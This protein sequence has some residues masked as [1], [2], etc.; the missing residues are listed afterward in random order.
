MCACLSCDPTANL[1]CNPGMC[2]DWE[3]NLQSFASQTHTESTE[4]H[5]PGQS[6]G[7]ILIG[8]CVY[9]DGFVHSRLLNI[10]NITSSVT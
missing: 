10:L 5:Q 1:D 6:V 9:S 7:I 8:H 3:S 2:P 4:L